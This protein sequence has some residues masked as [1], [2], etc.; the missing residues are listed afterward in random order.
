[1]K[2][3]TYLLALASISPMPTVSAV[4]TLEPIIV[5][6]TALGQQETIDD[7]Q[8]TIEVLDQ[9]TIQSLSGRN[10]SQ[11]LNEAAG[12]SVKDT[13]STAQVYMRGFSDDHALILVDGLRRTGKYGNADLSILMLE[14]IERI[15]IV[16]GAMSALYG[17][18][19]LSG[20][21][22]IITKKAAKE[23]R[24]S[25]TL[26]GGLADNND[27]DTGIVRA[28]ASIAGETVSHT[29]AVEF[30][31]RDDYRLDQATTATD[32][33]KES[34]QS[35]SYGNHIKWG[36]DSLQTRFEFLNQD[37]SSTG[38]D[39][40]GN[41][42]D[43]YEKEKRYQ[44]SG[45]HHH[46]TE[47]YLIDTNFAYGY[48]DAD[49]DRGQGSETTE[50]AQAEFNSYFRH[51]T[52]DSVINI[53]G[54]GI[55]REDIDVSINSQDA[56][57]S[58]YNLLYQNEWEITDNF[59]TVAGLRYDN[60]SD[61]G[62]TS[63]PRLSAKYIL[64]D[65]D[66]R[67]GYGEAF[68]APS[69]LNMYS[70]FKRGP[71]T[72]SGNPDLKPEESKTYEVAVGHNGDGYRLDLVYHYSKLNNLIDSVPDS[73]NRF[74]RVYNNIDKATISGAELSFTLTPIGGLSVKGSLEYLDSEDEST[75]ERLTDSARINAKLHLA[76]VHHA[77]S[78]FLNAKTSADY[79][80][81]PSLP[82][83]AAN[84][85]SNYT[86]FDAKVS[87]AYDTNIEL[88][89]GIDNILD[90]QMPDNMQL[91]G[92]PNDPGERYFYI[93]TTIKF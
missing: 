23:N 57:R 52:T 91:Y 76:Y 46:V 55:K 16:R 62:S 53:F 31:E 74:L 41:A 7:V 78:Y 27:R 22:N 34:K 86:V 45:I 92:T 89:G 79:Y 71:Y 14:D 66:F 73:T 80:A 49:I 43:E 60:Y 25:I 68:K 59:N 6:T 56:D 35:F 75:G 54:V 50:Y 2:L 8:A 13:G 32:L 51:F 37:D 64:G 38:T 9:K 84:T 85:N 12:I 40:S 63:N 1:M 65:T 39:R 48:S 87:Y 30:K 93:G 5:S 11:V 3:K 4:D 69:F 58:N 19:A 82:R 33:P 29:F 77:M 18:D 10:V 21:I 61:F 20:V 24:A 83:N 72:I 36:D 70:V 15:E 44:F 67:I 47:D 88:F 26:I 90:K 42:Y 81:A 28:N 17:A